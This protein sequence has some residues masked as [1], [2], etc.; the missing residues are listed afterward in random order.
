MSD[1][2]P[3][4][5]PNDFDAATQSGVVLV[6]FFATWCRPCQM[7]LPILEQI[8]PDF[9]GRAK[10]IKVDTD[11]AQNVAVRFNVQSIPTL[12]LLKNGTKV[13]QFVGLQ[14]AE[15][16]KTALEKALA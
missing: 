12:V 5:A 10:I 1:L 7:Q 3:I 4:V 11:Q 14:Q 8:A 15:T 6:D 13:A 16:L 2:I 9:T